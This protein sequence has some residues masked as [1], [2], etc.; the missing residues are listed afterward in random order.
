MVITHASMSGCCLTEPN[1]ESL[2]KPAG[3]GL[4]VQCLLSLAMSVPVPGTGS[5]VNH[6]SSLLW[7]LVERKGGE[8]GALRW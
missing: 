3:V 5:A 1:S 4:A 6:H 7:I 8:D 2:S